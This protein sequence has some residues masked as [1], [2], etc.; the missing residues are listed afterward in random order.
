MFKV[1]GFGE[2][3]LM[4]LPARSSAKGKLTV[5]ARARDVTLAAA[6]EAA[7]WKK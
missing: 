3:V 6:G 4:V 7:L 2:V 1:F 5:V